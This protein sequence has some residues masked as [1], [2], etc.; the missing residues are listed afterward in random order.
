MKF[1]FVFVVFILLVNQ[2]EARPQLDCKQ[3]KYNKLNVLCVVDLGNEKVSK[4]VKEFGEKLHRARNPPGLGF[5]FTEY[6]AKD[7]SYLKNY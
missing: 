1:I 2:Q 4:F 6:K 5:G 3:D 7:L